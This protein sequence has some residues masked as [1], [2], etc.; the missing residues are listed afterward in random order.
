MYKKFQKY[1]NE[2]QNNKYSSKLQINEH[3]AAE[4][5]SDMISDTN[6][7]NYQSVINNKSRKSTRKQDELVVEKW[8]QQKLIEYL[9]PSEKIHSIL[10]TIN[11]ETGKGIEFYF[12]DGAESFYKNQ[13][14][15]VLFGRVKSKQGEIEAK[16]MIQ[17]PKRLI[18]VFPK[19][20]EDL[21][22]VEQ[23]VRNKL[24]NDQKVVKISRVM[25]KYCFEINLDYR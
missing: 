18:F 12:L 1:K 10:N 4:L 6:V 20:G 7:K 22:S 25:K 21:D 5:N 15:L 17:N 8:K 16:I 24:G 3:M 9:P 14:S 13:M 23:E 19:R 11:Y 2:K